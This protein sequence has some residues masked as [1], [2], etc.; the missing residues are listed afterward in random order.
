MQAAEHPAPPPIHFPEA[1]MKGFQVAKKAT[2]NKSKAKNKAASNGG[3]PRIIE[4]K[5]GFTVTELLKNTLF[6]MEDG[7]RISNAQ[8]KDFVESL[9]AVVERELGEGKPVNLFHLTKIVPRLHTKGERM[10]NEVFGDPESKKVKKKYPAKVTLAVKR[11]SKIGG[12][13]GKEIMPT[14]QR[15]SKV[16]GA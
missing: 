14:V 2:K 11:G 9:V 7:T 3:A 13:N 1:T 16:V 15:L 4:S 8:A 5:K 10:V 12:K 6:T